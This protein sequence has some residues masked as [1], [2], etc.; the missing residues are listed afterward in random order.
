MRWLI[1]S[2]TLPAEVLE[3]RVAEIVSLQPLRQED[4]LILSNREGSGRHRATTR[5][6]VEETLEL[7][8]EV[9]HLPPRRVLRLLYLLT[10]T[11]SLIEVVH[12]T[13]VAFQRDPEA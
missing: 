8:T 2:D 9:V 4:V 1:S 11:G 5:E 6:A 13:F 3:R 10:T 7:M 12:E